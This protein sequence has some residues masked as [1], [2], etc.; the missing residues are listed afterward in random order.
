M[1]SFEYIERDNHPDVVQVGMFTHIKNIGMAVALKEGDQFIAIGNP[2]ETYR[3]WEGGKYL[4]GN[5]ARMKKPILFT[6]AGPATE[7][8]R[9]HMRA[10]VG[11]NRYG[12]YAHDICWKLETLER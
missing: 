6:L 9:W 11:N 12:G 10:M 7:L 4:G 2:N 1:E 8:A 5:C 3:Q